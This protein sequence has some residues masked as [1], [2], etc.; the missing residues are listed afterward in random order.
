VIEGRREEREGGDG[1]EDPNIFLSTKTNVLP[2]PRGPE[3]YIIYYRKSF[4]KFQ[5]SSRSKLL[6]VP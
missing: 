2:L 6:G 1:A 3:I 5:N 4:P